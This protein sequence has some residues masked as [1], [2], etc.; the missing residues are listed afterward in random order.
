[1]HPSGADVNKI[2][3][4]V[5]I[6]AAP[7]GEAPLW[8]RQKWVGLDLPVTRYA[9]RSK[10]LGLGALTMPR[11]WRGIPKFVWNQITSLKLGCK[12]I[13]RFG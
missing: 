3:W 4:T 8:V 5:R 10:F 9:G 6:I 13:P 7:P 2:D 11:S 1:M 12:R